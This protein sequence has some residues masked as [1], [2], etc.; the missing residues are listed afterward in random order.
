MNSGVR[1]TSKKLV[2]D[3]LEQSQETHVYSW[4]PDSATT[5]DGGTTTPDG[6]DF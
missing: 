3:R 1:S 4:S 6:G 5:P 2:V